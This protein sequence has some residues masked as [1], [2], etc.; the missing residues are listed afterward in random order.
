MCPIDL[1]N[2]VDGG[3]GALDGRR[4]PPEI[5]RMQRKISQGA[6]LHPKVTSVVLIG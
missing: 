3:K 2:R 1:F 5:A 6:H 4:R